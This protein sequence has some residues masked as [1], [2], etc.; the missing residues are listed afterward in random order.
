MHKVKMKMIVECELELNPSYYKEGASIEDMIECE[1]ESMN[2]DP[3]L[4]FSIMLDEDG[5]RL[6]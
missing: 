2:N 3:N 6:N 1:K 4:Y 5:A